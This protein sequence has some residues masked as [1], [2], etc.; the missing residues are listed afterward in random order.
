MSG[1][2]GRQLVFVTGKGGVGKTTV[3]LALAQV[4]AARGR[5]TVLCEV[6][7]HGRVPRLY[8]RRPGDDGVEVALEHDLH[9]VSIDPQRALE[10]YLAK[11]IGRAGAGLLAR[12]NTFAY[13][14]AA[15]PGAR[16][17]LAMG[18]AWDFVQP[19]RWNKSEGYDLVVVD[20]PASGHA[21]GMLRAPRTFAEIAR[22]GPIARQAGQI[23]DLLAD[24]ERSAVVAVTVPSEMPVTE[25]LELEDRL[26]DAMARRIA[27]VVANEVLPRRVDGDDLEDLS[28]ALDGDRRKLLRAAQR[29]AVS[30]AVRASGQERE[31]ARLAGELDTPIVQLP[32]LYEPELGLEAIA[33]LADVLDAEVD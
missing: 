17:L 15:A 16:E 6:G 22:V 32:F 13:F 9:A 21:L 28:T 5:R 12:S 23:R 4:A 8:G 31:L 10:E 30:E 14:V 11:N 18:K 27:L 24:D 20:G 25:T 7:A 19:V 3:A 26:E 29:A 2:L 1:L 33:Q